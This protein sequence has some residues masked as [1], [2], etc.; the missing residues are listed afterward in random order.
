MGTQFHP[1]LTP[2]WAWTLRH[3]LL[4]RRQIRI[5]KEAWSPPAVWESGHSKSFRGLRTLKFLVQGWLH[6]VSCHGDPGEHKGH[7]PDD[8]LGYGA[9]WDF[10]LLLPFRESLVWNGCI[11]ADGTASPK[12]PLV[13]VLCMAWWHQQL[14]LSA[15]RASALPFLWCLVVSLMFFMASVISMKKTRPRESKWSNGSHTA[16]K[17][18][19][20]DS[21][22]GYPL[23]QTIFSFSLSLTILLSALNHCAQGTLECSKLMWKDFFQ[24]EF[25]SATKAWPNT[26]APGKGCWSCVGSTTT[27]A[28]SNP[29]FR[30]TPSQDILLSWLT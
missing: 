3:S 22:P 29:H 14:S 12:C 20:L 21:Y 19:S 6:D 17:K 10:T 4:R 28:Q 11:P 13:T 25:A 18:K 9:S 30:N 24:S 1:S 26:H 7:Q 2:S 8:V 16:T 5:W 23:L 15:Q 27:H